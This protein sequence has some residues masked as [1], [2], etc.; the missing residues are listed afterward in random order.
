MHPHRIKETES[1]LALLGRT[2]RSCVC[3]W[4]FLH[5]TYVKIFPALQ[6]VAY[7]QGPVNLG[8][9]Y[10][11]LL[12]SVRQKNILT[13]CCFISISQVNHYIE[14][15]GRGANSATSLGIKIKTDKKR[16][17]KANFGASQDAGWGQNAPTCYNLFVHTS[18][19]VQ[20]SSKMRQKRFNGS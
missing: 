1:V 6:S 18:N 14:N 8:S 7:I 2:T 13:A 20:I 10:T 5:Y 16:K 9:I 19:F 12:S 11:A 17:K 3:F 4:W 15:L